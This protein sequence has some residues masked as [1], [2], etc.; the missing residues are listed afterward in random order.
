MAISFKKNVF[1]R[2]GL[3]SPAVIRSLKKPQNQSVS[4]N[5]VTLNETIAAASTGSFRYNLEGTG[6]RSTQQLNIDWT[7]FEN[8]T[9][10]NSAQVKLNVA[11]D[12]IL[13]GFPFDGTQKETE[14]YLDSLTGFENF[15]YDQY[16]KNVGYLFF[17]GTNS[18]YE[19]AGGTYVTVIDQAGAAYSA[20][21]RNQDGRSILNFTTNPLT[22]E[23]WLYVPEQTNDNQVILDRHVGNNG[24]LIGLNAA[25]STLF[26]TS[27]LYI[28]SGSNIDNVEV[29]FPK[30]QWNHFAWVWNRTPGFEGITTYINGELHASSSNL[31]EFNTINLNA[32]LY[33]GSGSA[34]PIAGFTPDNTLSGSI[35]DLRIWFSTRSQEEI[36]NY[37]K[38]SVYAD[39][40]LKAYYK[41]NEPSGSTSLIVVD[42]SSN[43]LHGRLSLGG[44]TLGVRNIATGSIAGPSPMIYEDLKLSPILFGNHPQ[45][46]SYRS[47]YSLSASLFDENNPNLITRLVPKHYF[48]EGQVESALETEQGPIIDQYQSG[49]DPRTTKLGATQTLLLLLYTWAKFFDEIKLY[50]QAF[51]DLGFVDYDNIDTVPDQMLY[52]IAKNQGFDLPAFFNGSSLE[53]FINAENIQNEYSTNQY[54]LQYI[55]N[56]I[57]RKILINLRDVISSKGTINAI[58]AYI[59]SIGIDPDNNFRMREYGGPSSRKLGFVRET[60][61]ELGSELSFQNSGSIVS[62]FLSASR[63][64]PGY[65]EITGTSSDGLFTS[66]SW[67]YEA[68]YRF[69]SDR[70][71]AISQSLVRFVTT[72]SSADGA[73][74]SNLVVLD[75]LNQD[76]KTIQLFVR[77]NASTTAP[78]LSLA[79]TGVDLFDNNRH[80]ISFGRQRNDDGLSSNV[81]S[82]YFLRV[83]KNNS[84]QLFEN[85]VTA[86]FFNEL[87]G[88]SQNIWENI[89]ASL[90]ASGSYFIIGSSS[91]D[92][93]ISSFLN[94]TT[95]IP[96]AARSIDFTGNVSQIRFWSKY[97]VEAEW[98]EHVRNFKSIGVQDPLTNFNFVSYKSG[99][100]QRLRIDASTKQPLT[101]TDSFGNIEIFD[102]SQN[103]LHLSGTGF[104]VDAEV[105]FPERILFS[106]LSPKYDLGGTTEKVRVRSYEQ[107][108]NVL[109]TPWASFAPIYNISKD[110]PTDDNRFTIDYSVVDA[111]DRDIVNILSTLDILDNVIGNP[112]LMF[113]PEYPGLNNLREVYFNR[114]TD[115]INFRN[116]FD[117]FKW[118]D[119]NIGTFIEQILP[120]KTQFLGI[121]YVIESHMLERP[122][123]YYRYNLTD[124][125]ILSF[126][127]GSFS[128]S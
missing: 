113:A 64:E 19:A 77:P 122:K 7:R 94:D 70:L 128:R 32:N 100:F 59:R 20:A 4:Y 110:I 66:G 41:F 91:V 68:T 85:Y 123:F 114:L 96:D 93:G 45:V 29:T 5:L 56:Q 108:E 121:N 3:F 35:D 105:I 38:K 95:N 50:L 125:I 12:K 26:G 40:T 82:S 10:F 13:N 103:E 18:G 52:T 69:P 25:S 126:L 33:I 37:Q 23:Y 117:F 97:L 118:F 80:Y 16:P 83:V 31:I 92:T 42:G 115:K 11:F 127:Q 36:Q 61:S 99:S 62:P 47:R 57:W 30:G 104:D 15:I 84:G 34:M 6:I 79:I 51:V 65:P 107:L 53:Q 98:K 17:S 60:K 67:T 102:F 89:D 27:S 9:F 112:E 81:S 87:S 72:G 28:A 124:S 24:Y 1:G 88:S 116:F 74:I 120:K 75:E 48:Y 54:S 44:Q 63:I 78:Y 8:H 39:E 14:I 49:D 109:E 76:S 106:Y 119:T 73:L 71:Y 86:S 111:L 21:S 101:Q 58:K 90:N 43:S 22:F 46:I 2:P 55:Q